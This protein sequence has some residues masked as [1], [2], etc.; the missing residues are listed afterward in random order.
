ML[1][2][3]PSTHVKMAKEQLKSKKEGARGESR[4]RPGCTD[5]GATL[6]TSHVDATMAMAFGMPFMP[7]LFIDFI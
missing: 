5:D 3:E 7:F 1:G 6:A 2:G 4:S